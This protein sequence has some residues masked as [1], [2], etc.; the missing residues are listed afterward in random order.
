MTLHICNRYLSFFGPPRLRI[1]L[2]RVATFRSVFLAASSNAHVWIYNK[3]KSNRI[4][5]NN[6]KNTEGTKYANKNYVQNGRIIP[7]NM[8]AIKSYSMMCFSASLLWKAKI[9][10]LVVRDKPVRRIQNTHH[11]YSWKVETNTRSSPL[12]LKKL[13]GR[14]NIQSN[15]K[16]DISDRE[17]GLISRK[18]T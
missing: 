12:K 8:R 5:E 4:I 1:E 16:V 2:L 11:D 15:Q 14:R 18:L 13:K 7:A 17:Y 10:K 6:W 3:N 9:F